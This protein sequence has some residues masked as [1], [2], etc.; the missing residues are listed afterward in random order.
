MLMGRSLPSPASVVSALQ[1]RAAHPTYGYT[2]QPQLIWERVARWLAAR[3]G[4]HGLRPCDFVFTA[5]LVSATVA[6][7]FT[8]WN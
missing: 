4:W 8:S 6:V 5:N 3:H 7:H 1:R 2:I